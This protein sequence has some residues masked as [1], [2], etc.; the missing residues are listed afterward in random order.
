MIAS[1]DR[2]FIK[3]RYHNIANEKQLCC[4]GHTLFAA[5]PELYGDFSVIADDDDEPP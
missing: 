3:Y 4:T 1:Y 5:C 2:K